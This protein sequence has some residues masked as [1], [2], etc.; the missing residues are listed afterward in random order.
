ML[1][2]YAL[3]TINSTPLS[4]SK[5]HPKSSL[6]SVKGQSIW[7]WAGRLAATRKRCRRYDGVS[8]S[9]GMIFPNSWTNCGDTWVR[10][11]RGE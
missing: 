10:K 6:A 8:A 4:R 7:G 11:N 1:F 2:S 9:V 3:F 5:A